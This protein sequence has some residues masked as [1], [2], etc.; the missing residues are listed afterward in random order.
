MITSVEIIKKEHIQIER[1]LVEI[2]I[3][4]DEN[5]VNYPNLIHVFKNL[6]NY[7]DSHE[8]KEELLLKSLGREGA[9]IEKMIL[10]HKELRGRKKVIQDAINSGN[11]L[12]L[13]ITLDTDARFFIDKVRKHIAQEEELFKSLW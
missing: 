1:E 9:V 2:E 13:K 6:F 7:W 12:E 4:I 3:I 8:E 11:E 10:Q 5:E